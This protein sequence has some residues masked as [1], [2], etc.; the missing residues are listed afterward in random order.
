MTAKTLGLTIP[1]E[2]V[3]AWSTQASAQLHQRGALDVTHT[4]SIEAPEP[5]RD[6]QSTLF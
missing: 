4:V 1:P 5:P 2:C 6:S 3:S